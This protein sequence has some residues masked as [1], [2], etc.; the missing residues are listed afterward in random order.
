[1]IKM[2]NLRG[3][4]IPLHRKPCFE[5]GGGGKIQTSATVVD[6]VGDKKTGKYNVL[7]DPDDY[8]YLKDKTRGERTYWRCRMR[9]KLDC[10]AM[11]CTMNDMLKFITH[12]H[13][14]QAR[15]APSHLNLAELF[16]TM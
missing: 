12:Y 3:S 11:A 15:T 10:K 6:K 4:I 13:T 2:A 14:H 8:E 7:V 9:Q 1:M 16:Q 5:G